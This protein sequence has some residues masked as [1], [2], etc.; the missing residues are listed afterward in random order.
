M[1]RRVK[2]FLIV[3]EKSFG[4]VPEGLIDGLAGLGTVRIF[5]MRLCIMTIFAGGDRKISQYG[6]SKVLRDGLFVIQMQ[7]QPL[8]IGSTHIGFDGS[9]QPVSDGN[10]TAALQDIIPVFVVDLGYDIKIF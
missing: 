2:G 6:S 8:G 1:G 9:F 3:Y 10:I 4:N 7:V 5:I